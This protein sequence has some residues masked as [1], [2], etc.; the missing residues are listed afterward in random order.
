MSTAAGYVASGANE[1]IEIQV[2][3]LNGEG[4]NFSLSGSAL[5]HEVQQMV[6]QQLPSKKGRRFVIHHENSPLLLHQTLQE[7]GIVGKTATLSCTFV[8][9]DL[10]AAFCYIQGLP[11]FEGERALEGL[12]RLKG[13]TSG[14][15]LQHLPK[16]LESIAF[17]HHFNQTL[18]GVSF[19]SSLKRLTLGDEFNQTLDGVS[20]P[21]S[22]QSLKFGFRFNQRLV[23]ASFPTS[24]KAMSGSPAPPTKTFTPRESG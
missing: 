1:A 19:P 2:L 21:S 8:P 14:E 7:Q 16:S 23:G 17:G 18:D 6:W 24:F 3:C 11:V 9:T 4:C 10:Y 12:T 15:Y 13:T 5:G 22:L 20:L